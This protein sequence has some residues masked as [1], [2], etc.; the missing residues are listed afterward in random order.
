MRI[1]TSIKVGINQ[2]KEITQKQARQILGDTEFNN[3]K[4]EFIELVN[5]ANGYSYLDYKVFFQG[6]VI[7]FERG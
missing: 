6:L 5:N 7:Y 2:Y 1:K 3:L 4:A